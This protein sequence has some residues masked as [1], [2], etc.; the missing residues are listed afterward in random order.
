MK[1]LYTLLCPCLLLVGCTPPNVP[2]QIPLTTPQRVAGWTTANVGLRW[3][4]WLRHDATGR[5]YLIVA[6][7]GFAGG[8]GIALT[9]TAPTVCTSPGE[10]P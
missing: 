5:C 3:V 7:Q 8:A 10:A 6:A 9:E 1:I 4:V 2:A